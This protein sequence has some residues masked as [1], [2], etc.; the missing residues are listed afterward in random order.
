MRITRT[1]AIALSVGVAAPALAQVQPLFV[2]E[3]SA[4]ADWVVDAKDAKL[5]AALEMLP[6]RLHELPREIPDM[7]A[8]QVMP[9]V[10]TLLSFASHPGRM[11]ITH[12]PDGSQLWGYG[13][14]CSSLLGTEQA[15]QQVQSGIVGMIRD[16]HAP[17]DLQR[18]SKYPGMNSV[19]TPAATVEFGPRKDGDAWRWELLAGS[20]ANPNQGFDALPTA[21]GFT[22]YLRAHLDLSALTPLADIG[23]QMAPNPMAGE[24]VGLFEDMGL[25][26][27]DAIKIDLLAG[28]TDAASTS[29]ATVHGA[30]PFAR[31]LGIPTTTLSDADLRAIPADSVMA[32]VSKVDFTQINDTLELMADFG[33]PVEDFLDEF[34]EA[35][36]VDLRE[37]IINSLGTSAAFYTSDSTGGGGLLS[38]VVMLGVGNHDRLAGAHTRLVALAHH[39]MQEDEFASRYVR[40]HAWRNDGVDMMS[41]RFNG[42]PIPLEISYALTDN[43]LVMSLTPQAVVTAVKQSRGQGD[44]GLATNA[45]YRAVM[46]SGRSLA[47]VSFLDTPRLARSGYPLVTLLGSAISNA[48]R[49][50]WNQRDPGMVVPPFNDLVRGSKATVSF[51]YWKGNDY[52]YESIADRSMLVQTA[53]VAGAMGQFMP[54]IAAAVLPAMMSARA[55]A[56]QQQEFMR[57]RMMTPH[58]GSTLDVLK[59]PQ[60]LARVIRSGVWAN[61]LGRAALVGLLARDS[62][63]EEAA[64]V[65]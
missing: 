45:A 39:A 22:P 63:I 4:M 6:D 11:A 46:P 36:G 61:P 8:G 53:G 62:A 33:L 25:I 51:S 29:I 2:L 24:I 20:V 59:S 47:S 7:P 1:L 55:A 32:S 44:G 60:R 48:M 3:H 43:W 12:D 17:F 27:E 13:F 16:S 65:E 30:K 49:S 9:L 54:V 64:G 50:P 31:E 58:Q 14:V 37:D 5:E 35:T 21:Q 28:Y 52:V 15:A 26:G 18:S 38:G 10:D 23:M 40:L 34:R 57:E 56:V 41:L 42:L 19:V